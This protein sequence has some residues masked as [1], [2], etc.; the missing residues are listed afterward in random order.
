M[1][2]STPKGPPSCRV[3]LQLWVNTWMSNSSSSRLLE[4]S[5]QMCW[6][7]NSPSGKMAVQKKYCTPLIYSVLIQ[8]T[9][10]ANRPEMNPTKKPFCDNAI[11][12]KLQWSHA[13]NH[14]HRLSCNGKTYSPLTLSINNTELDLPEKAK[15][16]KTAYK[17]YRDAQYRD[18]ILV[19]R[20]YSRLFYLSISVD[21]G[22][23]LADSGNACSF[24]L[25]WEHEHKICNLYTGVCMYFVLPQCELLSGGSRIH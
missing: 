1:S 8:A 3:Q 17:I 10:L 9:I 12:M 22:Y 15:T 2:N 14:S 7:L 11:N 18:T 6:E 13:H 4:T 23:I 24:P 19:I 25:I 5:W 20:Q 21:T 16:T